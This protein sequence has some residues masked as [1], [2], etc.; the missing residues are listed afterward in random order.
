L[1]GIHSHCNG[2]KDPT[3]CNCIV[4]KTFAGELR[5]DVTCKG[6][7]FVST[8]FDPFFDIS[9]ELSDA[10]EVITLTDCLT[11]FTNTEKL[12]FEEKIKCRACQSYQESTKQL[13]MKQ[14]PIVICFHLKVYFY[15]S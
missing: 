1:N 5:S 12:G 6:C 3:V 9:L 8:A 4:H 15:R 10:D 13:S 11:R 14:I 2:S 7:S